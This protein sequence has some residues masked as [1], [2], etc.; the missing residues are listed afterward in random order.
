MKLKFHYL[1]KE[2][3]KVQITTMNAWKSIEINLFKAK[4][5]ANQKYGFM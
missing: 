1:I 2:K 4:F 3:W 5:Q